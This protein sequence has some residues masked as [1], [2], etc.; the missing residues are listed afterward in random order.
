MELLAGS[1]SLDTSRAGVM[2]GLETGPHGMC[3]YRA[4]NDVVDH[5]VVSMETGR[6]LDRDSDHARPL[7]R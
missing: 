3:V 1:V 7:P 6:R 2:R 4:G 5:Q